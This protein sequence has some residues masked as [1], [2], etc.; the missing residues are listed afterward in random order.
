MTGLCA[1]VAVTAALVLWA[2]QPIK[3]PRSEILPRTGTVHLPQAGGAAPIGSGEPSRISTILGEMEWQRLAGAEFVETRVSMGQVPASAQDPELDWESVLGEESDEAKRTYTL[4]SGDQG[5][6][7]VADPWG[8][9]A[10]MAWVQADDDSFEAV[11]VLPFWADYVGV[12]DRHRPL[13]FPVDSGF[14]AFG[15]RMGATGEVSIARPGQELWRSADGRT[16]E[17]ADENPF[18]DVD[19]YIVL[20]AE[21][22]GRWVGIQ[23]PSVTGSGWVWISDDGLSWEQANESPLSFGW[24]SLRL[25]GGEMGWVARD[26]GDRPVWLSP[27]GIDWE[28]LPN[29]DVLFTGF[30]YVQGEVWVDEDLIIIDSGSLIG[31]VGWVGRLIETTAT[32]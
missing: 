3:T 24:C 31:S 18:G 4:V 28:P 13:V 5:S 20:L 2:V 9:S 23:P 7:V 11:G 16:W 25:T 26:C 1:G 32:G 12:G 17:P 19:G 10:T 15:R 29:Q 27:D 8:P 22:G 14:A 30:D 21:S 6:I